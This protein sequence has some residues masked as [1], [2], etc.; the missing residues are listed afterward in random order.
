MHRCLEGRPVSK[1]SIKYLSKQSV[2]IINFT[3][4][5]IHLKPKF[6]SRV[7]VISIEPKRVLCNMLNVQVQG[8]LHKHAGMRMCFFCANR[9]Y[10]C[11]TTL[12]Y[13]SVYIKIYNII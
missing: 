12:L 10:A 6:L 5:C 13:R 3:F 11:W 8:S 9:I 7:C 2:D 1:L 4:I